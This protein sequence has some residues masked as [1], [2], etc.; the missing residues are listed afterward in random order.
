M[1]I[2]DLADRRH[3]CDLLLD[4]NLGRSL[5]DYQGLVPGRCN[6]MTG[7][8]YALLRPEFASLREPSTKRRAA[9]SL[10]RI[11][12]SM[13][14]VDVPNAT[15]E[16]LQALRT[17]HLP[18]DCEITVVM[19]GTSPW[20]SQVRAVASEMPRPT[21]VLVG[22]SDMARVMAESDLAI[23]AA[24]S[25]SWE[26]CCLGLPSIVLVLADNQRFISSQLDRAGAANALHL[27]V[28]GLGALHRLID[29]Y[30]KPENLARM[31]AAAANVC[32]GLGAQRIGNKLY[33]Q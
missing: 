5:H 12:I 13:G 11:L 31:S 29:E 15:C 23:G 21:E 10:R 1:V 4:Q 19:G 20:L 25:T 7:P 24:G 17:A 14:G 22:V 2:D 33:E 32:D 8:D 30:S 28:D 9:P 26:R 6:V 18:P 16:V 27:S 3:Q